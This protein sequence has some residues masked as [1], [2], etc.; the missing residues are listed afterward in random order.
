MLKLVISGPGGSWFLFMLLP[1]YF[2]SPILKY[3]LDRKDLAKLFILAWFVLSVL[4]S[5]L[6]CLFPSVFNSAKSEYI[7][8]F[9]VYSGYFMIGGYCLKY[10]LSQNK[11]R[12]IVISSCVAI[13]A[14]A[15]GKPEGYFHN[16]TT[17]FCVIYSVGVFIAVSKIKQN[18]RFN[19]FIGKFSSYTMGIFVTH[20]F[21]LVVLHKLIVPVEKMWGIQFFFTYLLT[22]LVS[23]CITWVFK[24]FKFLKI[25]VS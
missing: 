17:P 19:K 15:L 22:L 4:F 2:V 13:I 6:K 8:V 3:I 7:G 14:M 20:A 23:I 5:N 25:F 11:K 9:S 21:V 16:F 18:I 12:A 24:R 10:G 1:L